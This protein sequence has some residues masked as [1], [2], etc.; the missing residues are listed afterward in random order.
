MRLTILTTMALRDPKAVEDMGED[1]D[2]DKDKDKDVEAASADPAVVE[3]RNATTV[4]TVY[5]V[6]LRHGNDS[7]PSTPSSISS[8]EKL[9]KLES[10]DISRTTT[11]S[12]SSSSKDAQ[13][14]KRIAKAILYLRLTRIGIRVITACISL[15]SFTTILYT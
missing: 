9:E 8:L 3:E 5:P 4:V 13:S 11:S 1:K 6:F 14:V 12:S 15:A 7:D 2:K 10:F